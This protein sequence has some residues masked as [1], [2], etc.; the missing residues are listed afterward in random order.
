MYLRVSDMGVSQ[1]AVDLVSELVWGSTATLPTIST[2][3]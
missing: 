2:A 3:K 1:E